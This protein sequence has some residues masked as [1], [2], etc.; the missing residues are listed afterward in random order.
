[1]ITQKNSSVVCKIITW[2]QNVK[3]NV[4]VSVFQG[5]PEMIYTSNF[6]VLT[7]VYVYYPPDIQTVGW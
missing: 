2:F 7:K 3:I 6:E 5:K 1:M 4:N